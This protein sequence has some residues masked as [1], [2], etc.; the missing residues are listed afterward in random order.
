[1][2]RRLE[3]LAFMASLVF[4]TGRFE[5]INELYVFGDSM[6]GCRYSVPGDGGNVS[7]ATDLLSGALLKWSGLG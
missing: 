6:S 3:L 1:M 7:T 2:V 4:P 5:P